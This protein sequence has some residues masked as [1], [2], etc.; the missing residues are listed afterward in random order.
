MSVFSGWRKRKNSIT[1]NPAKPTVPEI[2]E[3]VGIDET[4]RNGFATL[5]STHV[6]DDAEKEVVF[7]KGFDDFVQ[8]VRNPQ[9]QCVA[10]NFA[11][12][13]LLLGTHLVRLQDNNK[14]WRKIGEFIITLN[15]EKKEYTFQ[16]LTPLTGMEDTGM[17]Q[18]GTGLYHHPHISEYGAICMTDGAVQIKTA[19]ADG[20]LLE[21]CRIL[22]AAV[23][24]ANPGQ[25]PSATVEKWPL[26]EIQ[27]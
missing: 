23:F 17:E 16:N 5:C 25:Y 2:V 11:A 4:V 21:A 18:F 1:E 10:I 20:N 27:E 15:V 12:G 13:E 8:L 6:K 9:L 3:T 19:I 14:M 24:S 22:L 7:K 26:D